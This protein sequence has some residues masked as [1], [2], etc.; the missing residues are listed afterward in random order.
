METITEK[1]V[2]WWTLNIEPIIQEVTG[3]DGEPYY[4]PEY[5]CC[6]CKTAIGNGKDIGTPHEAS[7]CPG[8]RRYI[9]VGTKASGT[10]QS[11][12]LYDLGTVYQLNISDKQGFTKCHIFITELHS[13]HV[14]YNAAEPHLADYTFQVTGEIEFTPCLPCLP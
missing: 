9:K 4:S 7:V 13:T 12:K 6:K 10:F 8:G 1:D 2:V 5:Q 14:H 11:P 3:F